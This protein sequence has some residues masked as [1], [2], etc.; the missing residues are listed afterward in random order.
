[1]AIIRGR[2]KKGGGEIFTASMADIVFLLIVFF[3]LTYHT[4]VD[5]TKVQLPKTALRHE[6]DKKAAMVSI[7]SPTDP[8]GPEKIRVSTGEDMA[9]PVRSQEEIITFAQTVV[10]RDPNKQFVIKAD[11]AVHYEKIDEVLD[12][13]KQSKVKVIYLLSEQK[14]VDEN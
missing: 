5:R 4:E 3:V 8:N 6:I 1:M 12:A 9:L 13:L 2:E 11:S 10:A 7:A 14:T